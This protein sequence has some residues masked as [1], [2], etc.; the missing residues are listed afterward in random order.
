MAPTCPDN[1]NTNLIADHL[2]C[3]GRG[4]DFNSSKCD[5]FIVL[6]DLNIEVSN[7]FLEQFC[8]S[9]NLNSL[10]KDPTCFK[11]VDYLVFL[12]LVYPT[13]TNFNFYCS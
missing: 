10:I 3:L 7:L 5:N 1:P 2:H 4:I 12:K 9:Y 13:S 8:A 6:G 11:S